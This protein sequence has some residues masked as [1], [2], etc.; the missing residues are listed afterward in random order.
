MSVDRPQATRRAA[1]GTLAAGAVV[2]LGACGST[3]K[4]K[5]QPLPAVPAG[6]TVLR[7]LWKVGTGRVGIGFA[8]SIADGHVWAASDRG[9]VI[10]VDLETGKQ[11]WRAE[12]KQPLVAGI[13]SDGDIGVVATRDGQLVAIGGDG[14]VR[15]RAAIGSEIVSIPGIG[16]GLVVLRAADNRVSAWDADTGQRRWT[17]QRQ[18]PTLVLRQTNSPAVTPGAVFVGLPGGR[19]AALGA[20]SGALRWEAA[21]SVPKGSNEIERIADVVGQPVVTGR[22]VCAVSF[23][24]RLGCF[25]ETTGRALWA[26]DLSSAHGPATDGTLVVAV[27]ANDQ[28]HAFSRSGGSVWRTDAFKFRQLSGPALT[29]SMVL[30]GD[31]EGNL[32]ALSRDDGSVLARLRTDGSA[33]RAAPVVSGKIAVVQTAD[34]G[35]HAFTQE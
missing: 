30:V 20:Q 10:R 3:P 9:E 28:V 23:N 26:R 8:P 22:E 25:D 19:L 5:P 24:G 16:G 11:A 31:G 34:G 1:L 33:V 13:G 7:P 27:D 17:F 21:V 32:H 2:A 14:K 29:D 4:P 35:L 18:L 6:K 12:L 15:W